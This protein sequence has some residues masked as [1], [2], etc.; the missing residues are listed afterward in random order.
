MPL[1]P[2]TSTPIIIPVSDRTFNDTIIKQKAKFISL[3]HNQNDKESKATV[4]VEVY[5]YGN[6]NGDYGSL[7]TGPGFQPYTYNLTADND[8]IVK[9]ADGSIVAIRTDEP[10]EIWNAKALLCEDDVMFQGDFF[11]M[12]RETQSIKIGDLIRQH[13][14]NA[15][16][17]GRFIK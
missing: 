12:L 9:V 10:S 15:D 3:N 8:C 2:F 16:A 14:T 6:D 17:L 1:I 13:I 11:E 5:M 4:T 7:L